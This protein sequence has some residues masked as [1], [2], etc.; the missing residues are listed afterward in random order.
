MNPSVLLLAAVSQ[1]PLLPD[2]TNEALKSRIAKYEETLRQSGPLGPFRMTM[3]GG[4]AER[5]KELFWSHATGQCIRCHKIKGEGGEV[6]PDLSEWAPKANREQLLESLLLPDKK[7]TP[8][9]GMVTLSL[10]SAKIVTGVLRSEDKDKVE[11]VT[12][13]RKSLTIPTTSI[14]FRSDPKSVMPAVGQVLS[15]EES[16]DIIAYL[17]ELKKQ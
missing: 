14:E 5:G 12:P 2:G 11:L 16:R 1:P 17:A 4:D 9:Y 15:L 7:I 6:G 10:D 3:E 13:D 8:G